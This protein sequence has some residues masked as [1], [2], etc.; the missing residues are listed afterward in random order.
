MPMYKRNLLVAAFVFA[1]AAF[2]ATQNASADP[3]TNAPAVLDQPILDLQADFRPY[4]HPHFTRFPPRRFWHRCRLVP[5]RIC[6][7]TRPGLRPRCFIRLVRICI[8]C[9]PPSYAKRD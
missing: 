4:C 5:R 6:I 9:R 2:W 3:S 1:T 7:P 8:P